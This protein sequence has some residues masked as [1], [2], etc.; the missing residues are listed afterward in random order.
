[1]LCQAWRVVRSALELSDLGDV[2]QLL[3]DEETTV[4]DILDAADELLE[5]ADD[6][7]AVNG[8]TVSRGDM[9]EILSMIN[10]SFHEGSPSGFVTAFDVD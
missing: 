1:M 7:I 5:S 6:D 8:V 10:L 9:T 4:A 3:D 2:V